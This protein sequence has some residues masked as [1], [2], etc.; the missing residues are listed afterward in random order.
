LL[1]YIN[2]WFCLSDPA[3]PNGWG[4]DFLDLSRRG[5]ILTGAQFTMDITI[6]ASFE[7]EDF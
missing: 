7:I 1:D 4:P 2:I 5:F 3:L 6:T